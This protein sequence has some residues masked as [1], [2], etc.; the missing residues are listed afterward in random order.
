MFSLA[1]NSPK[2]RG[3]LDQTNYIKKDKRKQRGFFDQR[4]YTN[5]STWKLRGFFNHGNC[6]VKVLEITWIF[7]RSKLHQK[8]CVG[9]TWNF[10]PAKL[11]RKKY[12]ETMWIFQLAK[13]HRK[14]TWKWLGNLSKFGLRVSTWYQRGLSVGQYVKEI[15]PPATPKKHTA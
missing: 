13:L 10:W 14:S 12:V 4:N 2:Q 15:E 9:T 8:K 1:F 7:R 3:Y 11:H 5:K 6:M